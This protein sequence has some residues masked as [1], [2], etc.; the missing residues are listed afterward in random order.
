MQDVLDMMD[1]GG[2]LEAAPV[3]QVA[4]MSGSSEKPPLSQGRPAN[5][6]SSSRQPVS[7]LLQNSARSSKNTSRHIVLNV[8]EGSSLISSSESGV[9]GSFLCRSAAVPSGCSGEI[10][11]RSVS[12]TMTGNAS[13]S[14][15]GLAWVKPERQ[16]TL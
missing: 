10:I 14:A 13:K 11:A 3:Y 7:H 8:C 12:E 16:S 15:N 6:I 5:T 4:G 1:D 9:D 2:V